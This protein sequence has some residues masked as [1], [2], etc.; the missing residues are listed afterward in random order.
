MPERS[1]GSGHWVA[2]LFRQAD[3]CWRH[4]LG[5]MAGVTTTG[6]LVTSRGTA[7]YLL[8]QY[9]RHVLHASYCVSKQWALSVAVA[10]SDSS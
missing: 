8:V 4:G 3:V 7:R 6:V 10:G 1:G 2:A 5:R 9:R